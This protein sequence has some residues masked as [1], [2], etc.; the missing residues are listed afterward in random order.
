MRTSGA[1]GRYRG[2][3]F[4]QQMNE[5]Q[6]YLF[7]GA[8]L[9][10]VIVLSALWEFVLEDRVMPYVL[11]GVSE[12]TLAEHVAY[13]VTV[14]VFGLVSL[15]LPVVVG[16]RLIRE[17]RRLADEIRR[18]SEEDYLTGLPNRRKMTTLVARE[19][20]R[21][22]RYDC[23]FSVV[24]LDVDLFK[25]VNDRFGHQ[26]GDSVLR[27]LAQIIAKGIRA[28]DTASRWGGEEFLIL[29]PETPAERAALLAEKLRYQIAAH[30]FERIGSKT[31]SFGVAPSLPEDSLESIVR[32]VDQALYAA[33]HAGRNTI[34]LAAVR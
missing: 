4:S 19:I 24:L 26:T 22:R 32:R 25:D 14:G 5:R 11:P 29:C 10:S 7:L 18:L 12:E 34:K 6:Y 20:E 13:V 8:V 17:H 2:G 3:G 16:R 9:V 28:T 27:I 23:G 1:A 21:C 15:A 30:R 31:A 33:K